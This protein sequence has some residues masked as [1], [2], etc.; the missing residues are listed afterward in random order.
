MHKRIDTSPLQPQ[1]RTCLGLWI[2]LATPTAAW[3]QAAGLPDAEDLPEVAPAAP[4]PETPE[5]PRQDPAAPPQPDTG[6]AGEQSTPDDASPPDDAEVD[7]EVD[8]EPAADDLDGDFP[9]DLQEY[10]AVAV[11]PT[12]GARLSLRR[13]P[14]NVRRL[15]K[16]ELQRGHPLG[17]HDALHAQ[18]GGVVVNDVQNNPLQPDLQYR[19]YTASPLLGS[20]QGLAIYQNGVRINEPFGEVVQ[21]DLV[22]T[23]AIDELQLV[24]GSNPL[25][26]LGALGGSMALRLKNGFRNPGHGA[27]ALAGSFGRRQVVGEYG[28]SRNDWAVYAGVALFDEQGFRNA[29]PSRALNVSSDLRQRGDHHEVG[30]NLTLADTELYGNG[31]TPVELL[32]TDRSAVFTFPDITNNQLVLP[33]IDARV[34]LGQSSSLQATAYVRRLRRGTVNGDEAEFSL[35]ADAAGQQVLCNED[36]QPVLTEAG[37]TVNLPASRSEP[38][39]GLFNSTD[40]TSLGA[41]GS[42]QLL[43]EGDLAD[44]DNQLLVGTSYD[45]S[46]VEFHQ[47]AE[48]G[49]LTE[50][51][52]I[53]PEGT[54]L[55]G[56]QF[57]TGLDVRNHHLGVYGSDTFGVTDDLSVTASA[58]FNWAR[59]EM[60]DRVGAALDGEHTF[61][62][63]NP[64]LGVSYSPI[65][66]LTV[67]ASY[68]EANRVPSAAE[69]ACADP[70]APCRLP[71]AFVADPPL[72]QVVSR[73]V[74]LGLRGSHGPR[75]R[76]NLS[77]SVAGHAARN[78]GDILFVAGSRVGTGYFRNAGDTQRLGVELDVSGRAGPIELLASYA[79][80]HATYASPMRLPGGAHPDAVA[81]SGGDA[82]EGEDDDG[83]GFIAV[84]PGDRIPGL[85][86]HSVRAGVRVHPT[87]RWQLGIWGLGQSSQ[88]LRGDEANLLSPLDGYLVVNADSSY[89]LRDSLTVFVEARNVLDAQYETFGIV[90]DPSEVIPELQTPV[91][92]SPGA[93][94]G[95]WVGLQLDTR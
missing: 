51:R 95:V 20:P 40:T 54:F 59:I 64:A 63:V 32:A 45:G 47:R 38:Y 35:C 42:L 78:A 66:E 87:E 53:T 86:T 83:R 43:L 49:S 8:E 24:P 44:H 85:P 33:A 29:S 90:A 7:E 74:E 12:P 57:N 65:A 67:F 92:V 62:R 81:G 1:F 37:A 71:N 28:D 80:L 15:G 79:L 26:G 91:F 58:R 75:R 60:I 50:Q 13:T 82:D 48:L 72:H 22:P 2:V 56:E 11:V 93:P 88:Y 46:S 84:S 17:L 3:A 69:L 55:G 16:S 77:W 76:P 68:G 23:F 52:S 18:L 9:D 6:N 27:R 89:R 31:P 61:T 36:G 30:L 41:G 5:A 19:G 21:W 39:D 34:D 94:F 10:G 4:T 70:D 25:Y 14:R 73:S